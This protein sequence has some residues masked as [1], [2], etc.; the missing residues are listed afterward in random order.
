[1]RELTRMEAPAKP[2]GL[3]CPWCDAAEWRWNG[4]DWYAADAVT[5]KRHVCMTSEAVADRAEREARAAG[6]PLRRAFGKL[7]R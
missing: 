4:Y 3:A 1:L 6:G 2:T 5:H 7:L